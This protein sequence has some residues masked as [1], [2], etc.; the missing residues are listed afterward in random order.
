MTCDVVD[1]VDGVA[2]DQ[3]WSQDGLFKSDEIYRDELWK[4]MQSKVQEGVSAGRLEV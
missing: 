4:Y 1:L 3:W 2:D